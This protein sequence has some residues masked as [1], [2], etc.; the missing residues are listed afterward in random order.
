MTR[1]RAPDGGTAAV[2]FVLVGGLLTVL[3]G[4]LVQ[5]VLV[6]H[7]RNSL[8]DCAVEGARYG[9]L[10][11]RDPAA[12]VR[13]TRELITMDLSP[14][15]AEQISA[16]YRDLAGVGTVEVVVEAPLPVVGLLGS[17]R[18]VTVRGHAV[19]EPR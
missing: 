6:Q 4:A 12:A 18:R 14:R 2:E 5:L 15:Y 10:A 13:R 17:A 8:I 9:A 3:V 16:G 7:V 11:D 1:H 19:L